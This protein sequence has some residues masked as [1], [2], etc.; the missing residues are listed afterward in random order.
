M[1]DPEP[2]PNPYSMNS[3][4]QHCYCYHLSANTYTRKDINSTSASFKSSIWPMGVPLSIEQGLDDREE[5]TRSNRNKMADL[6]NQKDCE[7]AWPRE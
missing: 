3:D 5:D 4:P 1:L 7:H 6:A 2:Y